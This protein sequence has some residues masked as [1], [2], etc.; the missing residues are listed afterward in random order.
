MPE[1]PVYK[2][3]DVNFYEENS[4]Y[5]LS[6]GL[7]GHPD[8]SEW[9]FRLYKKITKENSE[10]IWEGDLQKLIQVILN[11]I[12]PKPSIRIVPVSEAQLEESDLAPTLDNA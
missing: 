10:R 2:S 7:R 1:H 9:D 11:S 4:K 8:N 3:I 12:E 6:V 5:S